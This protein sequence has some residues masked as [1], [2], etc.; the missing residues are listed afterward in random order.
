MYIVP[1][2]YDRY[3]SQ[4]HLSQAHPFNQTTDDARAEYAHIRE[5]THQSCV[6]ANIHVRI[7]LN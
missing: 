3:K 6:R 5:N 1:T 7:M 4:A 2:R